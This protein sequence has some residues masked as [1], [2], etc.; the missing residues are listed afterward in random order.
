MGWLDRMFKKDPV[1]QLRRAEERLEA[2]DPVS[3]L[4]DA[5]LLRDG[6]PEELRERAADL[7]NRAHD[8]ILVAALEKAERSEEA[9]YLDEAAD[10]VR[11]AL[12]HA[13]SDAQAAQLEAL[14]DSLEERAS[15]AGD[16]F[17]EE[18]GELGGGDETLEEG[19][20]LYSSLVAMLEEDVAERY[21][22][23]PD[24]F[25][26][27]FLDLNQARVEEAEAVFSRLVERDSSDPIPR[28]E[29]GRCRLL[30][31][32]FEEARDDFE[33][34]WP[35][36]GDLPLDLSGALSVPALWAE[37]QLALEEPEPVL[38]R[39]QDVGDAEGEDPVLAML[40]GQALLAAEQYEEAADH[41]RRAIASGLGTSPDFP[42]HL[43]LALARIDQRRQA[44]DLL[45]TSI[46]PSC[47]GGSCGS[48]A[49]HLPS[50]R[51]LA[52]LY[53]EAGDAGSAD[54]AGE[55]LELLN[56]AQGG[57]ATAPDQRLMARYYALHGDTEAAAQ[58]EAEA[59]RLEV[60]GGGIEELEEK[61]KLEFRKKRVL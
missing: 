56:R 21:E 27:A 12:E 20:A 32:R 6:G 48:Q 55:L 54:R 15:G 18:I 22:G 51:L 34:V 7:A 9:G 17:V 14:A 1:E 11:T 19:D 42:F 45:E 41:F 59:E 58:A 10:W 29:R 13:A 53:L 61:P 44:V 35:A 57:K 23:R 39:L 43:A 28:F 25:Q 33:A 50:F 52:R 30:Q 38:E 24:S 40:F 3:A 5:N 26:Q 37:A 36:L 31:G 2:G 47:A 16:R 49:K 46:A 4:Q 8:R 60:E